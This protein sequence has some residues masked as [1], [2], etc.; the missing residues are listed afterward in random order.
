MN[1][2]SLMASFSCAWSAASASKAPPRSS[3]PRWRP[4]ASPRS[5]SAVPSRSMSSVSHAALVERL[6]PSYVGEPECRPHSIQDRD[7]YSSSYNEDMDLTSTALSAAGQAGR[8]LP[9]SGPAV[10]LGARTARVTRGRP[11]PSCSNDAIRR[12]SRRGLLARALR[13][14]T[15]WSQRSVARQRIGE[16]T[17]DTPVVRAIRGG[18]R[19]GARC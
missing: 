12:H 9:A 15:S 16:N 6:S 17:L 10:F 18:R 11:G 13:D 1:G 3:A 14:S 4:A 5:P 7:L 8:V 2:S 19:G